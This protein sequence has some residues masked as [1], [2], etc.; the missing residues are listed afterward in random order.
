MNT[1]LDIILDSNCAMHINMIRLAEGY[2]EQEQ[3]GYEIDTQF[4]YELLMKAVYGYEVFDYINSLENN[5]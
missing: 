2:L 5:Q 1:N 4:A 3:Q